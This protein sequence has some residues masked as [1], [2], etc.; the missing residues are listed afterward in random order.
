[1]G[2]GCRWY[3]QPPAAR[4]QNPGYQYLDEGRVGPA[5]SV[6]QAGFHPSTV[7]RGCPVVDRRIWGSL[8]GPVTRHHLQRSWPVLVRAVWKAWAIAQHVQRE[9]I[10]FLAS[11]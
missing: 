10:G 1:M 7:L 5:T 9:Y 6:L 3:P 2:R 4:P 11:T 8:W